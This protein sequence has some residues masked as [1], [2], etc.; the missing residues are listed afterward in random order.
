MSDESIPLPSTS[1]ALIL[2]LQPLRQRCEVFGD[3]GCIDLPRAGQL[4]QCVRPG[5]ALTERKHFAETLAGFGVAVNRAFVQR[6][7]I[8]GSLA[9]RLVKLELQPGWWR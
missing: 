5:L 6:A 4:L 9:Q 8:A 3:G 1:L 7:F 2:L